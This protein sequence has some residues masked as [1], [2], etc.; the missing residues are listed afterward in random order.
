MTASEFKLTALFAK[1]YQI[2]NNSIK[3]G[4][5]VATEKYTTDWSWRLPLFVQVSCSGGRYVFCLLIMSFL[6]QDRPSGSQRTFRLVLP[7]VSALVVLRR[8]CH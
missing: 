3:G 1:G 4:M 5:M 7:R 8:T 2:I 6:S